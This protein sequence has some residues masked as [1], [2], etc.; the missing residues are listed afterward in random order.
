[1]VIDCPD[2]LLI[3][4]LAACTYAAA[5]SARLLGSRGGALADPE[6]VN[7]TEGDQLVWGRAAY[8]SSYRTTRGGN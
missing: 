2:F 5:R 1:M 8:E 7:S 4:A 6:P 3:V